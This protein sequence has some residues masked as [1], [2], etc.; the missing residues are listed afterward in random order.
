MVERRDLGSWLDGP[1]SA[2]SAQDHPGQR[3]GRPEEG[4]RS[5]GRFGRRLGGIAID[6]AI[7]LVGVEVAG[8]DARW[9]AALTLVALA[10]LHT[11]TIG[12]LGWSPGHRL[13]GLRVETVDGA[14]PGPLR[15]L[16]RS[17]LLALAV[18][19]LVWDADGRGMHDK[20]VGTLVARI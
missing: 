11:L 18:P 14:R 9:D 10:L 12:L 3:L 15:A 16:G 20:A 4:P 7:C 2:A 8:S 5:V 19:A 6:W 17:L 13:V 1:G